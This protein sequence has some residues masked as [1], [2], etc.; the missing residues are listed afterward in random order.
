MN[1]FLTR[2]VEMLAKAVLIVACV[3]ASVTLAGL[4]YH[5][6]ESELTVPVGP[7]G[8]TG[9]A[10]ADGEPGATGAEGPLG[11]TGPAGIT[12]PIGPAG[13]QGLTGPAGPTGPTGAQGATGATGATGT[14]GL[15]GFQ[16]PQGATGAT[17]ATGTTGPTGN[18]RFI[19]G[20]QYYA[21]QSAGDGGSISGSTWSVRTINTVVPGGTLHD[22]FTSLASN[23]I[24]FQP[25]IYR[26]YVTASQTDID[27]NMMRIRDT[28]TSTTVGGGLSAMTSGPTVAIGV[29]NATTTRAVQI[30]HWGQFTVTNGQGFAVT[31]SPGVLNT[32][33]LVEILKMYT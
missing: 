2:N 26:I 32:Y 5:Q 30:Q 3:I 7:T 4:Y 12:G 22:V 6:H 8:A 23:T 15:Q 21:H 16:G 24:T 18:S 14:T 27:R 33:L 20:I 25:G 1:T 11:D 31:G 17:G 28:T 29:L 13:A 9:V 10:G 19:T